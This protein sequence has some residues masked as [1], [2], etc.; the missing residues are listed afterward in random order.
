M[1]WYD[2]LKFLHVTA[3]AVWVGGALAIQ[4]FGV[5]TSRA[6]DPAR[7]AAFGRDSYWFVTRVI[8]P[9]SLVVGATG[10][11]L[12]DNGNWDWSE[13]FI[14]FGFL[15]WAG[16]SLVAFGYVA[17]QLGATGR[18]MAVEGPQPELLA[19]VR[20]LIL[21]ARV[22]IGLLVLVIFLMTVKPGT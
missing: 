5:L 18:R 8:L 17:R 9:S 14:T 15:L 21:I 3:V 20:T 13:P 2:L 7:S 12:T 16:I 10:I 22:L 6:Q 1:S 11:G 19:R 4:V